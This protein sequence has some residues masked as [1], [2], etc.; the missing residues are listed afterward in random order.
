MIRIGLW[1]ILHQNCNGESPFKDEFLGS[2]L[3]P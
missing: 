2:Y 3:D 1:D